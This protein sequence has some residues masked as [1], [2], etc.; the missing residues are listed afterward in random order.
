LCKELC[1]DDP[2]SWFNAAPPK[3]VDSWIAYESVLADERTATNDESVSP[4]KALE[5]LSEKYG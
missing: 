1:I 4:A 2:I 3:V 5:Q